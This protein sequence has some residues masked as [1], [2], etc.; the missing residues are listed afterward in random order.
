[1]RSVKKKRE[2]GICVVFKSKGVWPFGLWLL[3]GPGSG[4][5]RDFDRGFGVLL[6]LVLLRLLAY[7]SST[8]SIYTPLKKGKQAPHQ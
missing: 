5:G 2:G 8:S 7:S 1:M 4:A 6:G 3:V